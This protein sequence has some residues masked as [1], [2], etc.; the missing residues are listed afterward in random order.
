MDRETRRKKNAFIV[1]D[2]ALCAE[3]RTWLCSL[4]PLVTA[5]NTARSVDQTRL[6]SHED[7]KHAADETG[8]VILRPAA[9][10][11]DGSSC[12]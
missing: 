3:P 12:A 9:V 4:A 2:I 6:T 7:I 10:R 11:G 8:E 1:G 5:Q